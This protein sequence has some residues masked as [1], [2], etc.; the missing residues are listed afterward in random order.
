[1]RPVHAIQST[2]NL[3]K[4]YR[5]RQ[6]IPTSVLYAVM[7]II[8]PIVSCPQMIVASV[9]AALTINLPTG[10]LGDNYD[11]GGCVCSPQ[12]P[13]TTFLAAKTIASP[14]VGELRHGRFR[15]GLGSGVEATTSA[16]LAQR[17]SVYFSAVARR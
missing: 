13:P 5:G 4:H 16:V 6:N 15:G 7:I 12:R 10:H 8:H 11:G 1:M 9:V 3:M 2:P 14:S 17:W